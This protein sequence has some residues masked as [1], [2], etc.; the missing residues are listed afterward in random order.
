MQNVSLD[1]FTDAI[2]AVYGSSGP[3]YVTIDPPA[4]LVSKSFNIG[5]GDGVLPTG[6]TVA[7]PIHYTPYSTPTSDNM[8]LAFQINNQPAT[9]YLDGYQMTS[10]PPSSTTG[11]VAM[12]ITFDHATGLPSGVTASATPRNPSARTTTDT[13]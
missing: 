10:I 6:T 3:P 4:A 11:R 8:T 7:I 9:I 13:W 1:L 2:Q 12:G 5:A